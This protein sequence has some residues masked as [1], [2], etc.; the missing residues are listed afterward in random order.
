MAFD[1]AKIANLALG[2]VGVS[3]YISSLADTGQ[4]A[5]V[6]NQVYEITRDMVLADVEWPFAKKFVELELIHNTEDDPADGPMPWASDWTFSYRYPVDCLTARSIVLTGR[7]ETVA[8]PFEVSTDVAGRIIYTDA[9]S[10]ILRYTRKVEDA[11]L[12]SA[13]F[14]DALAWRI[15]AEIAMPLAQSINVRVACEQRYLMAISRAAANAINENKRDPNPDSE[16]ISG[17][18]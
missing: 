13:D 14:I 18:A 5:T 4:D 11:S 3:R 7:N 9:E 16:F 1:V 12:F 10:P 6:V 17:R 2:R 15:A 8:V